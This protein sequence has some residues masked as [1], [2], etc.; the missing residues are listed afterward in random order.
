MTTLTVFT[1]SSKGFTKFCDRDCYPMI[2]PHVHM[3][4]I[5]KHISVEPEPW[6]H[7]KI[8]LMVATQIM[9]PPSSQPQTQ[10]MYNWTKTCTFRDKKCCRFSFTINMLQL[11]QIYTNP[12]A[13][14]FSIFILTCISMY[15]SWSKTKQG[16]LLSIPTTMCDNS[17]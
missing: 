8:F 16:L 2:G 11:Q 12:A 7:L 4:P 5:K 13:E 17:I 10:I 6:S 3:G 14:S 9:V 15:I 1:R